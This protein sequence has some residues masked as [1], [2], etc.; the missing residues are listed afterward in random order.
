MIMDKTIDKSNQYNLLLQQKYCA[1]NM[2]DKANDVLDDKASKI[3]Q[4][5]SLIIALTGLLASPFIG[6]SITDVSY[7]WVAAILIAF[8]FMVGLSIVSIKPKLYYIPGTQNWDKNFNQYVLS[9]PEDGF[10]QILSDCLETIDILTETNRKKG[11]LV[12]LSAYLLIFQVVGLL[13]FI[14]FTIT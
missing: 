12:R 7:F 14:Y 5:S 4:A 9:S 10:N 13:W 2:I 11:N 1:L 6:A 8:M 3:M